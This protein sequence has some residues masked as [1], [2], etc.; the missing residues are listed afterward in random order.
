MRRNP[1]ISVSTINYFDSRCPAALPADL[2]NP[3]RVISRNLELGN[4]GHDSFLHGTQDLVAARFEADGLD[5]NWRHIAEQSLAALRP[6]GWLELQMV[7]PLTSDDG[8][9]DGTALGAIPR[10]LTKNHDGADRSG[11]APVHAGVLASAGFEEVTVVNRR[12]W[13]S[14]VDHRADVDEVEARLAGMYVAEAEAA[15]LLEAQCEEIRTYLRWTPEETAGFLRTVRAEI[16]DP[17]IQ[18]YFPV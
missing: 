13:S 17:S 9:V 1:K 3:P 18:A 4:W 7:G 10:H 8:S 12:W 2:A 6:G 5:W 16:E 14:P 11:V 15:Q